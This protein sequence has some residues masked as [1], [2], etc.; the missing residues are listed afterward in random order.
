MNLQE[1]QL[2]IEFSMFSN[3]MWDDGICLAQRQ[4]ILIS[5]RKNDENREPRQKEYVLI[6]VCI[7]ILRCYDKEPFSKP[8]QENIP[9]P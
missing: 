2:S 5:T 9:H 4:C 7:R 1:K 8:F 3:V 6:N